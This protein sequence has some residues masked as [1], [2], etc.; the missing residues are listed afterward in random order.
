MLTLQCQRCLRWLGHVH[1]MVDGRIPK[2]LFYGE[3]IRTTGARCRGR[4]QLRFKGVC[5]RDLKLRNI[6]TKLWEALADDR[7]LWK[8]QVS[9]G[10][11]SGEPAI[12]VINGCKKGQ[13]DSLSPACRTNQTHDLHLLSCVR[14]AA[15]TANQHWP[16][17]PH[18]TLFPDK[19]SWC[20]CIVVEID[21]RMPIIGYHGVSFLGR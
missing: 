2:D 19:P 5:K 16:L 8:Q 9:Q 17:Q 18:K 13:K 7:N 14:V 12:R 6:D 4:P 21:W 15:E 3:L 20:Y 1:R 10:L 11:K